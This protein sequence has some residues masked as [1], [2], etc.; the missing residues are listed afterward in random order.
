MQISLKAADGFQPGGYL[1]LPDETPKGGIIVLQE[2]FGVNRHIREVAD[3]F[4]GEGYAALAPALFDRQQRGFECGYSKDEAAEARR[5]IANPNFDEYML[6]VAAARDRLS[7]YGAVAPVGYC[8]G[9]AVAFA[10]ATRLDGLACAVGYYG[11]RIM[12]MRD[13]T[14]RCPVLLHFGDSDHSIPQ[15]N[16]EAIRA[17]RPDVEVHVYAA[18]HGFNCDHREAFSAEASTL[19]WERTMDFLHEHIT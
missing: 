12:A 4:A 5:F 14:P 19:A 3:R 11:A 10:A 15:E 6:D 16:V 13:E 18:G 9:G 1:A 17:A 2:I 8:L 7:E